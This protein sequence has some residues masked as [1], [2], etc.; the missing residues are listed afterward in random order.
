MTFLFIHRFSL[1]SLIELVL[2][3]FGSVWAFIVS[4]VIT[5]GLDVTCSAYV[6]ANSA[7]EDIPLV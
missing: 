5:A 6:D 3:A 1:F 7:L 2:S 4:V